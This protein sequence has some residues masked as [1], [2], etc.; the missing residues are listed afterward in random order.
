VTN[1]LLNVTVLVVLGA[2][3]APVLRRLRP[4]PLVWGAVLMVA[5]TV[6]FDTLMI[7]ADLYVFDPDR[8]LGVYVWGAPVEDFGYALAA[9]ALMPAL[10]TWL[11]RRR[12]GGSRGRADGAGDERA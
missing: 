1:A 2:V 6:V 9:S 11:G 8:I 3:V 4:G 12:D 7:A 5:L 10:W